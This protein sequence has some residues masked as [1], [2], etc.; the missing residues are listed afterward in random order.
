MALVNGTNN[1]VNGDPVHVNGSGSGAA[2]A[3]IKNKAAL[4]RAKQKK[5]KHAAASRESSVVCTLQYMQCFML[6][7]TLDTL[8]SRLR[9]F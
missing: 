8:G 6:I 1:P 3:K 7:S 9:C 4:K 2:S 5:A